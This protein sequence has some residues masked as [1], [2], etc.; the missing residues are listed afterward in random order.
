MSGSKPAFERAP[1]IRVAVPQV[2]QVTIMANA[3][4]SDRVG[5]P[6]SPTTE[7]HSGIEVVSFNCSISEA[8][9]SFQDRGKAALE[10]TKSANAKVGSCA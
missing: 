5:P 8:P 7:L 10:V 9:S 3:K 1:A 6:P 4:E 2:A